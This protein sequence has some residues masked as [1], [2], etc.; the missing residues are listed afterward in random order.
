M[1]RIFVHGVGAVSPAGWDVPTLLA[2]LSADQP[3]PPAALT[4]PGRETTLQVRTVPA[5]TVRHPALSH[6]RLR[7]ASAL[8][9]HSVCAAL[10]ALGP[11]AEQVRRG[12]L[13]LGLI[14]TTLT[15]CVNYSRR[16]Y[17]EVLKAPQ[18]ASPLLF[19]ETVFNAP[20]SHLAAFLEVP[21]AYYTLIGDEG[22]LAQGLAIAAQWLATN[23]LDGCVIIGGEEMDWT[24]AE[25]VQLF[26]HNAIFGAGAGAIYLRRELNPCFPVEL[27]A[28]TDSFI[29]T[30]QQNRKTAVEQMHAQMNACG[31]GL[32]VGDLRGVLGLGFNAA[33]AW[34][35][36]VACTA[37][38]T[39]EPPAAN[40]RIQGVNQQAIGVRFIAPPGVGKL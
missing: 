29:Y 26:R 37:I 17:E 28:I 22:S 14:V 25:A 18:T 3:L 33:C 7:R 24:V 38:A 30:R 35:C 16:F 2:A 20:A 34:R 32:E 23:R 5:A 9:Q 31:S 36:V 11:D 27:G 15:G 40:V 39:G 13:R 8:T 12:Q 21:C 19:P 1:S 6:P 10:E 4:R